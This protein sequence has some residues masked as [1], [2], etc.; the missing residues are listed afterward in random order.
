MDDEHGKGS[1]KKPE[2]LAQILFHFT[3]DKQICGE[4]QWLLKQSN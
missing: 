3:G 4:C 2:T 1:Q